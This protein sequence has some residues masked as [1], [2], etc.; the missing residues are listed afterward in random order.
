MECRRD[1]LGLI[2]VKELALL[3]LEAGT[4]VSDVKMRPLP[5][6]RADTAM[7]AIPFLLTQLIW[8]SPWTHPLSFSQGIAPPHSASIDITAIDNP[9]QSPAWLFFVPSFYN[10]ERSVIPIAH[11]GE[12]KMPEKIGTLDPM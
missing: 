5:M 3:D 2:I 4:R 6:L 10:T 8:R 9:S 12:H 7:C 11:Q 1:V